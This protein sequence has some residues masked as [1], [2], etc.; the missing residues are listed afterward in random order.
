[1]LS[2]P[3]L[4]AT[5]AAADNGSTSQDP[6]SPPQHVENTAMELE[7]R[8]PICLDRWE[9]T[10]YVTPCLHQF[11]YLCILQW[12]E[13]KPECPLCK[14][15]ILSIMHWVQAD[16]NFDEDVI[17]PPAEPSAVRC[18]AGGVPDGPATQSLHHPAAAPS[19]PTG[20]LPS[21]PEGDLQPSTWAYLFGNHPG[22][23]Q[24]ILTW[25]HQ[26]L[27]LIFENQHSRTATVEGLIVSL[28]IL[29][30]L[31]EDLLVQLLQSSL[32][33]HTATF[34]HQLI[35]VAV[36]QCSGEARR[37]LVLEVT[38]AAGGQDRSPVASTSSTASQEGSSTPGLAAP[39]SPEGTNDFNLPRTAA[40]AHNENPG[41]H[42]SAPIPIAREQEEP[43]EDAAGPSP[44][45]RGTERSPG[46]PRRHLKRRAGSPE[47]SSPA[48]KRPPRWQD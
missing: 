31:D 35:D 44:V 26:E 33:T 45:S 9:D 13:T 23:L 16:D 15:I 36:Q 20:L 27:G 34:V 19:Q 38:Q 25:M 41:S 18:Q 29:F 46:E 8:C 39:I 21:P 43:E 12:A 22:L 40:A 11:C 14:S 6:P 17:T 1:M 5:P 2:L 48:K 32:Q 4:N 24:P 7:N 10:S 47:A 3:G 30:G 37:L 42:L 28:L